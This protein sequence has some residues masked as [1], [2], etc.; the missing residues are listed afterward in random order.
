[1][2]RES[3]EKLYRTQLGI[4]KPSEINLIEV[5][6]YLGVTV[7]ERPLKGCEARIIGF[8]DRAIITV[9][10]ESPRT[11]QLFSIGHELGHWLKHRGAIGSLCKSESVLAN[12]SSLDSVIAGKEKIANEYASELLM[13]SYLFAPHI[14]GSDVSFDVIESIRQTFAVSLSAAAIRYVNFCQYPVILACYSSTRRMWYHKS[15]LVPHWFYPVRAIDKSSPSYAHALRGD[16]TPLVGLVDA[17]TWID[18]PQSENY[19]VMETVWATGRGTYKAF[20]W[21]EN[22]EHILRSDEDNEDEA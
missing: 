16:L 5:A 3:I 10:E 8:N 11:R 15:R 18:A 9:N 4:T 22:E 20:I 6:K 19:E 14:Q 1:M 13:P 7:K 12:R 2:S 17:D 21:W